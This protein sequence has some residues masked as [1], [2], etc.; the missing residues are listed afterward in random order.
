MF[1]DESLLFAEIFSVYVNNVY[2]S[3][4]QPK[5]NSIGIF[6]ECLGKKEITLAVLTDISLF[7]LFLN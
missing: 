4:F 3:Y 1:R 5:F 7:C 2:E 6:H